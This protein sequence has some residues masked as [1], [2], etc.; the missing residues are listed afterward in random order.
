PDRWLHRIGSERACFLACGGDAPGRDI[1]RAPDMKAG[2]FELG[3]LAADQRPVL[4]KMPTGEG[5]QLTVI[6][7]T[8]SGKTHTLYRIIENLPKNRPL[9][10]ADAEQD[11]IPLRAHRNFVLVGKGRDLPAS[12]ALA[13]LL[14]T[15]FLQHGFSII[16]DAFEEDNKDRER[17]L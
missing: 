8:G 2:T 16:F 12:P 4:L 15:R 17:F 9:F 6:G 13:P 11:F 10:I 1:S 3:H 5:F 14:A 7:A